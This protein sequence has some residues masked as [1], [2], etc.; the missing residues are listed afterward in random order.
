MCLF[1]YS[2]PSNL[3][4]LI[5]DLNTLNH[6]H[7]RQFPTESS[8]LEYN[9]IVTWLCYILKVNNNYYTLYMYINILLYYCVL[10]FPGYGNITPKTAI[11]KMVTMVYALIGIPLMLVY[12]SSIGGLLAWCARGIFTR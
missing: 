2:F 5:F 7:E 8:I 1:F 9:I 11:G 4:I 6:Y 12:L 10:L 3:S